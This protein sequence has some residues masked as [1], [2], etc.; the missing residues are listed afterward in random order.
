MSGNTVSPIAT[1]VKGGAW[2][3]ATILGL[4]GVQLAGDWTVDAVEIPGRPV[5]A[6]TGVKLL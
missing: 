4:L 1:L 5:F 6:G 2:Q 3:Q